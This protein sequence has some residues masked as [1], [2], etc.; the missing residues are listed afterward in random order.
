MQSQWR[1]GWPWLMRGDN[2][3]IMARRRVVMMTASVGRDDDGVVSVTSLGSVAI[4]DARVGS[5]SLII[6]HRAMIDRIV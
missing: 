1:L 3:G 5:T 2:G 6:A 4:I